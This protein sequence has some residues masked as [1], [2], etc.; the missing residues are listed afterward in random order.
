MAR[1]ALV[2]P[3]KARG[4]EEIIIRAARSGQ[5]REKVIE[6]G[7][8]AATL[9]L[10]QCWHSVQQCL[11]AQGA[12]RKVVWLGGVLCRAAH[13]TSSSALAAGAHC[14]QVSEE[15][16]IELLEQVNEQTQT[17]TKVCVVDG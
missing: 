6:C 12:R 4:V 16:L 10:L 15:R 11:Q 14:L 1:I 7:T 13:T 8:S 3:D 17:K 5:I 2:K 9:A